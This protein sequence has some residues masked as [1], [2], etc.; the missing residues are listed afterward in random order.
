MTNLIY[1][2]RHD[3]KAMT[4]PEIHHLAPAAFAQRPV[5]TASDRYGHVT[6]IDAVEILADYGYQPV[7][8]AQKNCHKWSRHRHAEHLI[9]FAKL[10]A[11]NYTPEGRPEIIIYNSSDKTSSLKIFSGF[12]RNIC[13]NGI[14]AGEGFDNKVNHSKTAIKGFEDMLRNTAANLPKML[15]II[16]RMKSITIS[17]MSAQWLA[18]RAASLRWDA[19]P[20]ISFGTDR[21][22]G[23]FYNGDTVRDMI[24]PRRA[25]EELLTGPDAAPNANLWDVFNRAQEGAIRGGVAIQSYKTNTGENGVN[26]YAIKHRKARP[27]GSLAKTVQINRGLWDIAADY[28]EVA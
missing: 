21:I 3:N 24:A 25:G 23:S 17:Q 27:I 10:N 15:D 1:S 22:S 2:R 8:A 19:S 26:H 16:E 6:T 14:H 11:E 5:D 28:M 18:H 13:S 7:Q 12:F 20:G 9:S 4:L